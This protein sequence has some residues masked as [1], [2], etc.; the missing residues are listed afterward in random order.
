MKIPSR[1]SR[2]MSYDLDVY[3]R[4]S[5]GFHQRS[6]AFLVQSVRDLL[7]IGKG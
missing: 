5:D 6:Y 2:R 1:K 4:S 3:D 7:A